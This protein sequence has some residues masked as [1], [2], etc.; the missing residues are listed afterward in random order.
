[1]V[2]IQLHPPKFRINHFNLS[3]IIVSVPQ[4]QSVAGGG[5]VK[6][7]KTSVATCADGKDKWCLVLETYV[8]ER[9]RT[10]EDMSVLSWRP[11]IM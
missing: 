8:I 2:V 3:G 10:E 11:I 6:D 9:W 7:K 4:P 1:M 5:F